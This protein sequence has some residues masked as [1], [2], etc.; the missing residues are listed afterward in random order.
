MGYIREA[1]AALKKHG[2]KITAPRRTVISVLDEVK[3]PLSP[4]EIQKRLLG[5]G[6]DLN[7]VAIY[8]VL[9]GIDS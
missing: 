7:H 2:Y 3:N 1:E 5:D 9:G 8:R 4:Y 6:I